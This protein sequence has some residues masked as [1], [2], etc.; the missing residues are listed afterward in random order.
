MSAEPA[1]VRAVP[2]NDDAQRRQTQL[3]ESFTMFIRE[4]YTVIQRFLLGV[5][6]DPELVEDALQEALIT[7]R[8]KWED[9]SQ[10]EKPLFWV[11]KTAWYKLLGL[12]KDSRATM[13]LDDVS[14]E[15]FA[16]P[17]SPREAQLMVQS[18]LRQLPQ[19][20]AAVI[21]LAADGHTDEEICQQLDL[22]QTTVRTYKAAARRKLRELAEQ[23]EYDAATRRRS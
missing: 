21:A 13:R 7:T 6:S 22:A 11:R 8:A 18:L 2:T 15:A 4:N 19:R 12:Q 14:P 10:F 9:V 20:Q 16:E 1:A 5:C 23:A 17:T 3:D